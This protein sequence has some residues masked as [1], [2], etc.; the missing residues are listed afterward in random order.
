MVQDNKA[1]SPRRSQLRSGIGL[2]VGVQKDTN[3]MYMH[4]IPTYNRRI[5]KRISPCDPPVPILG[6]HTKDSVSVPER[7][8]HIMFSVAKQSEDEGS[9]E[10]QQEINEKQDIAS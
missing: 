4:N 7:S 2:F 10:I 3:P 9:L 5:K 6:V 1:D 8:L